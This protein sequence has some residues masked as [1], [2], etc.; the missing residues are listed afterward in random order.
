M[1]P[2]VI[3]VRVKH[4]RDLISEDLVD[5]G[6]GLPVGPVEEGSL[7][8]SHGEEVVKDGPEVVFAEAVVILVE[9]VTGQESR[10]ALELL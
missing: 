4:F 3:L 5:L 10:Y 8:L 6:V 2:D 9:Q 7:G 1:D